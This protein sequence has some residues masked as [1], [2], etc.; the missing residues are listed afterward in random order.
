MPLILKKNIDDLATIAV[1][2]INEPLSYF[3]AALRL[4]E[5][6]LDRLEM[7]KP[8]RKREWLTSRFLVNEICPSEQRLRIYKNEPG[9]PTLEDDSAFISISH[10]K[11]RIAVIKSKVLVGIDIQEED[12]RMPSLYKRFMS[13]SEQDMMDM[14]NQNSAYHIFWGAKE[15]MYKAY[16]K[17][18]LDFKENMGVYP[19][20]YYQTNLELSGW[21]KKNDIHQQYR[22][23]TEKLNE[24]YLNYAI[25]IN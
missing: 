21:V 17:K 24:Y 5:E 1:W 22:I 10:S 19:F 15:C 11:D 14:N 4:D 12:P 18:Q 2:D 3:Q 9:K 20:K 25:L 8:F 13:E 16:G 23:Y 6:E 7:M